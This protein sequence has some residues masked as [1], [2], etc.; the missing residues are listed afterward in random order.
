MKKVKQLFCS[1][2]RIFI[3]VHQ[4][5]GEEYI[6]LHTITL[7]ENILHRKVVPNAINANSLKTSSKRNSGVTR[8]LNW[9]GQAL[10][11]RKN[12][13]RCDKLCL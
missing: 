6:T 5:C 10:N 13:T 12:Q 4:S 3:R 11:T 7:F 1:N 9:G 8:K 2:S